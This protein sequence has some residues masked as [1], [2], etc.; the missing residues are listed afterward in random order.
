MVLFIHRTT[1]DTD[2]QRY[3]TEVVDIS[4][5]IEKHRNGPTGEIPLRFHNKYVTMLPP[6]NSYQDDL[7]GDVKNESIE[8]V[9]V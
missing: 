8:R 7:D 9:A 1:T 5:L 2:E 3:K 6:E 4:L